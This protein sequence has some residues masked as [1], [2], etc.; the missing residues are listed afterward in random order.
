MIKNFLNKDIDLKDHL[1]KYRTMLNK[2]YP[3]PSAKKLVEPE[4]IASPTKAGGDKKS[5]G[6]KRIPGKEAE[7]VEDTHHEPEELTNEKSIMDIDS[8]IDDNEEPEFTKKA[9]YMRGA[10]L[11]PEILNKLENAPRR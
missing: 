3:D 7:K 6:G 5:A 10:P 9:Q 11:S 8:V 2:K 1:S 4:E